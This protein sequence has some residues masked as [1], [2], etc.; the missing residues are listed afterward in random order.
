MK[1][2]DGRKLNR[3][4]LAEM[5]KRAVELV[6]NGES[7]E[8][9][10][11][12]LGF[13]RSWIYRALAAF[14]KS[15]DAG[16]DVHSAVGREPLL[17]EKKRLII[18]KTILG[19]TPD[20]LKLEF[21]L[22]TTDQVAAYVLRRWGIVLSISTVTRLL[23]EMGLSFQKPIVKA[24]QQ[25]PEAVQNWLDTEYPKI[26]RLAK[27]EKA[28][29]YF[30]DEAGLRSDHHSGRTWGI[31]G[32]TPIVKA[33]GARFRF[34]VISAVNNKGK[35]S[36]M[37]LDSKFGSDEFINFLERL[38]RYK[39]NKIFLI[40]DGH[41][42]HKSK[43]VKEWVEKNK[44][45]IAL[46]YLPPY[47]PELNPTELTWNIMKNEMGK[48]T[49]TGPDN[50]KEHASMILNRFETNNELIISFYQEDHVLYAA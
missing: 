19:K 29:I 43:K 46:F 44:K 16:L 45:R 21:A 2:R 48:K 50:M 28:E 27:K 17:D 36:F 26:K 14:E 12:N 41:P 47:S 24:F 25:N 38:I 15:G 39:R 32:K 7:P 35:F 23:H 1:I 37:I 49:I 18:K 42:V 40:V 4:T 33:T 6:R 31:K 10:A 11:I 34:N 9:V 5:R 8:D 30:E 13:H 22:W 20:Q 3:K